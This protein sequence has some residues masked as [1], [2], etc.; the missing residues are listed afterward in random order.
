MHQL[1]RPSAEIILAGF[2]T[3]LT[4]AVIPEQECAC[5]DPCGCGLFGVGR[6]FP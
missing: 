5:P 6:D 3:A 4:L 2:A 1:D